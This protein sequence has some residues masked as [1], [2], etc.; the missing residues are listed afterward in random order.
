MNWGLVLILFCGFMSL[1]VVALCVGLMFAFRKMIREH[2][3]IERKRV[4]R[5]GC[6]GTGSCNF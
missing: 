1:N 5:I 2:E 3:L 6:S 4:D